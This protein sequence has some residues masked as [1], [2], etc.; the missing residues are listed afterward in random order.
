MIERMRKIDDTLSHVKSVVGRRVAGNDRSLGFHHLVDDGSADSN[1]FVVT[2]SPGFDTHRLESAFAIAKDDEAPIGFD[3]Q[4]EQEIEYFCQ[5]LVA[6]NRFT[7][8]VSDLCQRQQFL[9]RPDAVV[10]TGV[11]R[12]D[13]KS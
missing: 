13:F 4:I 1:L 3:K 10:G 2:L 6:F 11:M 5:H 9:F 7:Q 8:R 12:R